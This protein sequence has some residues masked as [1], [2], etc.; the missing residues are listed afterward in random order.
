[1]NERKHGHD[2]KRLIQLTEPDL[3]LVDEPRKDLDECLLP[4]DVRK[5]FKPSYANSDLSISRHVDR[6]M[7]F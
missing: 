6:K 1:M 7:R 3:T 2:L 5:R 4:G